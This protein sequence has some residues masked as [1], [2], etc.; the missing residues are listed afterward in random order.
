LERA[1]ESAADRGL[2][3]VLGQAAELRAVEVGAVEQVVVEEQ[4]A[5]PEAGQVVVEAEDQAVDQVAA[6]RL[7]LRWVVRDINPGCNFRRSRR[8]GFLR[9]G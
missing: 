1:G 6:D 5:G 4:A 2:D 7:R 9:E 8:L 3:Q